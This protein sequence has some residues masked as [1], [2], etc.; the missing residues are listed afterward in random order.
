MKE[1][2]E[3]GVLE[4]VYRPRQSDGER[5]YYIPYRSPLAGAPV[6]RLFVG[7]IL[8]GNC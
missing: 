8:A 1:Q 5:I 3:Q 6:W 2:I 4:R 7:M